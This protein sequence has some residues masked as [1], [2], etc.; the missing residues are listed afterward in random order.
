MSVSKRA[1][2]KC[3]PRG[4]FSEFYGIREKSSFQANSLR[5]LNDTGLDAL[6]SFGSTNDSR[7]VQN[8]NLIIHQSFKSETMGIILLL[9][10]L[11]DS[12]S[13]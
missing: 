4:L 3:K 1:F 9:R 8:A 6:H 2:E 10:D 12:R 7:W 13:S 5:S 11:I